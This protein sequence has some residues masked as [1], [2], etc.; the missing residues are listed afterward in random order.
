MADVAY[1]SAEFTP[2]VLH[3][4][5]ELSPPTTE[6]CPSVRHSLTSGNISLLV[7]T[8]DEIRVHDIQRC[9]NIALSVPVLLQEKWNGTFEVYFW[10]EK[11]QE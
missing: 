9:V 7:L 5:N 2:L 6:R 11:Q 8:N 4:V 1:D 3:F 10:P